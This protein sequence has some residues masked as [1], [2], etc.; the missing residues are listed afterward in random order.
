MKLSVFL[1]VAVLL[2]TLTLPMGAF[3]QQTAQDFLNR[4]T[5]EAGNSVVSEF[6]CDQSFSFYF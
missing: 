5:V 6:K 3:G 4:I 2:A 1:G